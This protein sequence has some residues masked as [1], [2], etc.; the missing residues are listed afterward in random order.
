MTP[1]QASRLLDFVEL[2][3]RWNRTYNLTA[4]RD[5]QHMLSHHVVDC[6]A[7][8]APLRRKLAG[9][10]SPRALDVG[11]GGGLPGVV[12]AVMDPTLHVTCVDSV[13]KKA[14]FVQ[15]VSASLGLDNL[16]ARHVRVESLADGRYDVIACRAFASLVDFTGL[17]ARLL[18]SNGCWLALKGKVPTA[19]ISALPSSVEV[20]HVEHLVVPGVDGE[21]CLVWMRPAADRKA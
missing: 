15:Q 6:L 10:S 3:M 16:V 7:A 11:S 19:E 17:S 9:R 14:A 2:L 8:V 5:L 20:F 18:K 12:F 4:I 1:Q 21:R 13:G